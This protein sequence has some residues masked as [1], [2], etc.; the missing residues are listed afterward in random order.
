MDSFNKQPIQIPGLA[1]IG[2][3]ASEQLGID[4]VGSIRTLPA[5]DESAIVE[6]ETMMLVMGRSGVDPHSYSCGRRQIGP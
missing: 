3:S 1:N 2:K 6:F 4:N 5:L